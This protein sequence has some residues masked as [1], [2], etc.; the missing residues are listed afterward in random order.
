MPNHLET[1]RAILDRYSTYRGRLNLPGEGFERAFRGWL[2]MD[3]LRDAL[4]WPTSRIFFGE[5]F[6]VLLLDED[7]YP[8]INIETKAPDHE[9]SAQ[10]IQDFEKRLP[11][12][13]TLRWAFFT[14]GKDWCR[15]ALY[16]PEGRQTIT[17]RETLS[18]QSATDGSTADFFGPL[19][20]PRLLGLAVWSTA[21][22]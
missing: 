14:N 12:Y 17:K 13:G 16:A 10:E 2:V 15:L 9:A 20:P 1:M 7:L 18:I 3:Y 19:D 22:E 8:I 21:S 4:G 5:R 6:D 11:F